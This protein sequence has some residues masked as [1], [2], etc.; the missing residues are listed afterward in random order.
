MIHHSTELRKG[1]TAGDLSARRERLK[2]MLDLGYC[3]EVVLIAMAEQYLRS[4]KWSWRG[5]LR[6]W[7]MQLPEWL[8]WCTSRT[9]REVCREPM[10]DFEAEMRG[11]LSPRKKS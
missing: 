5:T 1:Q 6:A 2:K 3:P 7:Q 10:E 8:L 11:V 4:F 9:Y